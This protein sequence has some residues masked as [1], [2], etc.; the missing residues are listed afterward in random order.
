MAGL[1][2]KVQY[3]HMCAT[4]RCHVNTQ[5]MKD[6][7]DTVEG[8]RAL[9][10]LDFSRSMLGGS[11]VEPLV[12]AILRHCSGLQV[13]N[14]SQNYLNDNSIIQLCEALTE[15][16]PSLVSLDLSNNPLSN[17]AG[18][19]LLRFIDSMPSLKY[20]SVQKTLMRDNMLRLF[21][22][23]STKLSPATTCQRPSTLTTMTNT[24]TSDTIGIQQEI[25]ASSLNVTAREETQSLQ[26]KVQWP[27]LKTIWRA[28]AIAA[29][30][31]QAYSRLHLLMSMT[32]EE[33]Y[34]GNKTN[35]ATPL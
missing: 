14:L 33:Q 30:T 17:K 31:P 10:K 25:S 27:A 13:L 12:E 16:S 15:Y 11:D 8:L 7:P 29:P 3:T 28:A 32:S 4:A 22:Q 18:R 35:S 21:P 1:P 19:Y 34:E 9:R 26:Q 6:L 23:S 20:I 5:L 24:S 2:P